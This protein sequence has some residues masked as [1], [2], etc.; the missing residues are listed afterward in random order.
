MVYEYGV[1]GTL[2]GLNAHCVSGIHIS[3]FLDQR[4]DVDQQHQMTSWLAMVSAT[5]G[6]QYRSSFVFAS[7]LFFF[8]RVSL[9]LRL[10]L[11]MVRASDLAPWVG[12][13]F[14]SQRRGSGIVNGC[15]SIHY[16]SILNDLSWQR[17]MSSTCT[18]LQVGM[19]SFSTCTAYR[20]SGHKKLITSEY[21]LDAEKATR[22]AIPA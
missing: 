10:L 14:A 9:F 17:K 20:A 7:F 12:D 1:I 3:F 6:Y 22:L 5:H 2:R 16:R 19:Q 18:K 4:D 8:L 11:P 15:Y 13:L 21:I